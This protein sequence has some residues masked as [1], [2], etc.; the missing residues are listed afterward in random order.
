MLQ[1]LILILSCLS[2]SVLPSIAQDDMM[3]KIRQL[4]QQIQELK[5]LKA[6]QSITAVKSDQCMKAFAREKFCDCVSTNLPLN[7][8][9]EQYV[10]TVIT[11]LDTLGYDAMSTEQKKVVDDT[12]AVREKCVEKGFFK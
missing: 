12:I 2:L 9:F 11:P 1:R 7:V 10:H 3:E 8:N 5:I 6:Q 4:E